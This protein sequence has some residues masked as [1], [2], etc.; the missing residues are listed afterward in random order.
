MTTA[1]VLQAGIAKVQNRVMH[2]SEQ[3]HGE[4][5][6]SILERFSRLDAGENTAQGSVEGTA[7]M[8][9]PVVAVPVLPGDPGLSGQKLQRAINR[10]QNPGPQGIDEEAW[11]KPAAQ[12]EG[13]G[14]NAHKSDAVTPGERKMSGRAKAAGSLGMASEAKKGNFSHAIGR[15]ILEQMGRAG[16]QR[17]QPAVPLR[18][19]TVNADGPPL[20][21]TGKSKLREQLLKKPSDLASNT[22]GRG[23]G[24]SSRVAALRKRVEVAQNNPEKAGKGKARFIEEKKP[25]GRPF[26]FRAGHK[27]E[28]DRRVVQGKT[29]TYDE[30]SPL[31]LQRNT[32]G[33]ASQVQKQN[34]LNDLLAQKKDAGLFSERSGRAGGEREIV[35]TLSRYESTSQIIQPK[36]NYQLFKNAD[37]NFN[38]IVR[39]FTLLLNK[40]G[41]EA[42]L[43]LQPESLGSL[44]LSIRLAH[45]EVSTS[46]VVDNQMV[47]ELI[48]S[49]LPALERSLEEHGFFL[50]SFEVGVRDGEPEREPMQE[51]QRNGMVSVR[52]AYRL[53][54]PLSIGSNATVPYLPWLSTVVNIMV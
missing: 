37:G 49:R 19:E 42:R 47:R 29:P 17:S 32:E 1:E 16:A 43:V 12:G 31:R 24:L 46:I 48:V 36:T 25:G 9:S 14:T 5:F 51:E 23:A 38:E 28:N 26:V 39:Q 52:K 8:V 35:S 7:S 3:G 44:R 30:N 41:G 4:I 2:H 6:F 27:D 33:A 18:K 34:V 53:R 45:K 15:K 50:G 20:A 22:D 40:G 11:G 21:G 13:L 54:E 10:A